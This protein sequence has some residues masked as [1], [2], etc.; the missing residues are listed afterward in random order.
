MILHH[1]Y[2]YIF[3]YLNVLAYHF[4]VGSFFASLRFSVQ[5][6][7]SPALDHLRTRYIEVVKDKIV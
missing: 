4:G 2:I 6:D 5:E 7:A 1:I 3:M